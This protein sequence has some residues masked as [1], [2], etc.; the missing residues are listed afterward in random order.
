MATR[1][2]YLEG[3]DVTS[4]EAQVTTVSRT[5][6]GLTDVQLDATCFYPRGG[7]QDW[8]EGTIT[9]SD[10]STVFDV[11]EVRLDENGDVHHVGS[12][13][14]G[15][16]QAGVTVRCSV[17]EGRRAINTRLHSAGHVVDMAIDALGLDWV[18]TKGQHYPHL[19]AVEYSGEWRAE[20]A[21]ELRHAIE[22][23]A[24]ELVLA[25]TE[26]TIRFMPVEEMHTVCRHVPDDI[27]KNKPGRVVL[28]GEHFGIPCGGTH[29]GN[30]AQIGTI[31]VS[32]LSQKKGVIRVSYSVEGIN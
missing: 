17:D 13:Q 25:G 3:F 32:K 6:E 29:V 28:Y 2:L 24:N 18:A 5:G 22:L 8:D 16:L 10:G 11:R 14:Q 15:E 1:L 9:G 26:N 27:P 12:Y 19:S 7:G 4:C 20:K 21:E 31:H 23:K 30:L